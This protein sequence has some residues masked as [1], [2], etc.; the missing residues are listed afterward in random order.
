MFIYRVIKWL[1]KGV[2]HA[3]ESGYADLLA[4]ELLD[5]ANG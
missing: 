4:V 2:F 3:L 5:W 1:E